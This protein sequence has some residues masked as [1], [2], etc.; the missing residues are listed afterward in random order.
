MKISVFGCSHSG[1]G[2]RK[3]NQTWPYFLHKFTGLEISNFAIGGS[4]TQFQYEIFND[5]IGN[6]DKFIF[7]FTVPYRLTKQIGPINQKKFGTYTYFPSMTA[8][9]LERST[10]GKFNEE[11]KEWIKNDD[12]E[13]LNEYKNICK[14]V[15]NHEK[16]LFSFYMMRHKSNVQDIE[17]MQNNFPKLITDTGIHLQMKE[18]KKIATY[19]KEK[20]K[21]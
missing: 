12:G 7:Q 2:P 14:E 3:W 21:L 15:S 18:N 4:S 17:I 19:I 8:N 6:F 1:I 11:Y 16:C 9:N 10:A 5:N 13:I 20:C